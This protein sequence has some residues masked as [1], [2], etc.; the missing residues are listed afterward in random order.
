MAFISLK[1][2]AGIVPRRGRQHLDAP[3]ATE[4]ENCNLYSGELRPLK[5]PALV[6]KFCTPANDCWRQPLPE[7]PSNPPEPPP[8][9]PQCV[10]V[11][12]QPIG[13]DACKIY[14]CDSLETVGL[15]QHYPLYDPSVSSNMNKSTIQTNGAISDFYWIADYTGVQQWPTGSNGAVQ[16]DL[17]VGGE[18]I[19][20]CTASLGIG[21]NGSPGLKW[22]TDDAQ[23]AGASVNEYMYNANIS[24]VFRNVFPTGQRSILQNNWTWRYRNSSSE[25]YDN[26]AFGFNVSTDSSNTLE[27]NFQGGPYLTWDLSAYSLNSDTPHLLQ[28]TVAG[29]ERYVNIGGEVNGYQ[30]TQLHIDFVID[31]RID[32]HVFTA[33]VADVWKI[34]HYQLVAAPDPVEILSPNKTYFDTTFIGTV[35]SVTLGALSETDKGEVYQAYLQNFISY[36]DP[37]PTCSDSN[38]LPGPIEGGTVIQI[39]VT[40]NADATPPIQY[41]WYKNNIAIPGEVGPVLDYTLLQADSNASFTVLVQNPCGQQLSNAI[42]VGEVTGPYVPPGPPD[43]DPEPEPPPPLGGT[44]KVY[45]CDEYENAIEPIV[46]YLWPASSIVPAVPPTLIPPPDPPDPEVDPF[47]ANVQAL[48]H[49]EDTPLND[50]YIF[51]TDEKGGDWSITGVQGVLTTAESRFTGGT[52]FASEAAACAVWPSEP[53]PTTA[54]ELVNI[55]KYEYLVQGTDS[56]T[57]EVAVKPDSLTDYYNTIIDSGGKYQYIRGIWL[58]K[59]PNG[60]L[61]FNMSNGLGT[62]ATGMPGDTVP[63]S[64]YRIQTAPGTLPSQGGWYDIAV[65]LDVA[66]DTVRLYVDGV[67]VGTDTK[68]PAIPYAPTTPATYEGVTLRFG[69]DYHVFNGH[70]WN[71]YIDEIRITKSVARYTG[72]YT[73]TDQP[74]PPPDNY[75][76]PPPE[77]TDGTKGY[78]TALK[79]GFDLYE[80][81]VDDAFI[82]SEQ[83]IDTCTGGEALGIGRTGTTSFEDNENEL[84]STPRI[85]MKYT[86]SVGALVK[87][88]SEN[89]FPAGIFDIRWG[90]GNTGDLSKTFDFVVFREEGGNLSISQDG[91]NQSGDVGRETFLWANVDLTLNVMHSIIINYELRPDSTYLEFEILIDGLS[92]GVRSSNRTTGAFPP[93]QLRDGNRFLVGGQGSGPILLGNYIHFSNYKMTEEQ[94]AILYRAAQQ[95]LLT[96]VDPDPTCVPP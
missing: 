39:Q 93:Y 79:G 50:N 15:F 95:N 18:D 83:V 91:P 41:Q 23:I 33:Q 36:I 85:P 81:N 38:L 77:Y 26:L 61:I 28:V 19:T 92:K 57:I 89:G 86:G 74:F 78:T 71:G 35:H 40:V 14:E 51:V 96:Y 66:T 4:A 55:A 46:E 17:S 21:I 44:C 59:Q 60:S 67:V 10:P 52:C 76:P 94:A 42:T 27:F 80:T 16:V 20:F 3:H 32:D 73:P 56:W 54:Q 58:Q 22:A 37:D 63:Y 53:N 9:P 6:H 8:E 87:F 12:S 30:Q 84:S 29:V 7:D 68:D 24:G 64:P 82:Y 72:A 1:W 34:N 88:E 49:L 48:V 75:I 65:E 2:F 31:V 11:V 25:S 43:P 13:V 5:K 45:A 69:T 62:P 90:S 47:W 70:G